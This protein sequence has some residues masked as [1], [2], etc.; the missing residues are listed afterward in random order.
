MSKR[1]SWTR[2]LGR[3]AL[4]LC[5]CCTVLSCAVNPVTR[6]H[7]LAISEKEEISIGE[8]AARKIQEEFGYYDGVPELNPYI[9][10]VG[11]KLV[12]HCERKDLIYHFQVLDTPV[13]NAFALPGGYVYITRGILARMNSEDELATVLGHE[14]THVAARHSAQ[15]IAKAR[16]AQVSMM[17]LSVF[18]P[19]AAYALGDLANLALQ[20]A[21]LGYSRK[22]EHQADEYGIT[23]AERAGYNP[24]GAVRMFRMFE[25]LEDHEPG[26]ME[27][28]LMSHPPTKDRLAYAKERVKEEEKTDPA[29]V[30]EPLRRNT[31]L[32][33]LDGLLLGQVHGKKLIVD[34]VF[35]DKLNKVS[36]TFPDTYQ[37]N[38]NPKTDLVVLTREIKIGGEDSKK[39]TTRIIGLEIKA[40]HKPGTPEEHIKRF[41]EGIHAKTVGKGGKEIKTKD[42]ET[43]SLYTVDLKNSKGVAI[44]AVIG[45]L[46]RDKENYIIYGLTEKS[47][48]K[49]A[50]PEFEKT[51][52]TFR[53]LKDEELASIQPLKLKIIQAVQGDTWK[54]ISRREFG[55]EKY[56]PELAAYNGFMQSDKQPE[57]GT[58][59]KIPGRQ[60]LMAK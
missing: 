8:Q 33:H 5:L 58:L 17:L 14:L 32:R 28:F 40:L 30:A 7:N 42:G 56:A 35:Y 13:I 21:F 11:E 1:W 50:R 37:A 9:N 54:S 46:I 47:R 41:L 51:I 43:L 25:S 27:R 59:I 57:A 15:Q 53:F 24:K 36:F 23:Y 34:N 19:Q 2:R 18:Q 48:F 60:S 22:L 49:E 44:R 3:G 26:R 39:V 45:F 52:E 31:F 29:Q 38:L 20:F 55:D 4:G 16:A 10:D 12:A 6:K